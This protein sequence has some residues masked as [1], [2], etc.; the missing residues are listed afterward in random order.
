M[1]GRIAR[2]LRKEKDDI[3]HGR[4]MKNRSGKEDV[5][6]VTEKEKGGTTTTRAKEKERVLESF[7]T[8]RVRI[9]SPVGSHGDRWR[10]SGKRKGITRIGH[11]RKEKE[12]KEKEEE[13]GRAGKECRR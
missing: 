5:E 6:K 11:L 7:G 2:W 8:T 4:I 10:M 3:R 9:G 13:K 1:N 12:R